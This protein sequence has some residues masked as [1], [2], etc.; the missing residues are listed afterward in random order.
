VMV[1]VS[2]TFPVKPPL[3]ATVIVDVLFVVAPGL[4]VTEVPA[5]GETGRRSR[6]RTS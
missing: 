4:T 6:G 3:A 1:A 2:V 5:Y